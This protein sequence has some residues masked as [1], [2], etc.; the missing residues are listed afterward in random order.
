M[1]KSILIILLACWQTLAIAALTTQIDPSLA[2]LG[3]TIRLTLSQINTQSNAQPD[4]TPLQ[5]DFTIIGT[6]QQL[7]Y[8]AINGVAQSSKQWT[9]LLVAKKEGQLTIPSIQIG[10]ERS[11]PREISITA[12]TH[13]SQTATSMDE[14]AIKLETSISKPTAYINEQVIYTVKL[15]SD[16]PLL[17]AEYHAPHIKNGLIM[18]L[19]EG[20]TSQTT[21][22]GH[23]YNVDEQ[24]YAI[25]PQKSG[26]LDI[27]PPVFSG[28]VYDTT[29]RR[30]LL[31]GTEA[32]VA[33]KPIPKTHKGPD[34]LPAKKVTLSDEYDTTDTTVAQGHAV[35]RTI[36]I[37]AVGM[38]AE[39]LPTLTMANS[40]AFH[41]YP[42][43]PTTDNRFKDD[44][45]VGTRTMNVTY[46]FHKGGPVT[47]PALKLEWF[48]TQTGRT[49]QATLAGHTFDILAKTHEGTQKTPT[50]TKTITQPKS[51][52]LHL[53][54]RWLIPVLTIGFACLSFMTLGWFGYQK[55]TRRAPAEPLR[56]AS[57]I[58]NPESAKKSILAWATLQWPKD[59]ILNLSDV[60]AR[61][62]EPELK[63]EIEALSTTLYSPN[64]TKSPWDGHRL[65]KRLLRYRAKTTAKKTTS[66][67]LP[68]L[69]RTDC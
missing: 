3:E 57:I 43:K 2:S 54:L 68:T 69:Y 11:A 67:A 8:T 42:E 37:R 52:T 13:H 63:Q 62:Q 28:F 19:G 41:V 24:Q 20:Q 22:N 55:R 33:V 40:D 39:L 64:K 44:N 14:P 12:P 60:A 16:Q 29:P 34:W 21:L 27:T 18:P 25:F 56:K 4:L 31:S 48:N 45:L 35:V 17:N 36:I 7:S 49:E 61:I 32:S 59:E 9:I 15:Y 30:I 46:L 38:P 66:T 50:A 26:P 51:P 47:V 65:W 58:E 53:S 23:R 5:Q 6:A 1:R 10:H